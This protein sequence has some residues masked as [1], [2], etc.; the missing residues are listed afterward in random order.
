MRFAKIV[1]TLGPSSSDK[2]TI[3]KL[4]KAGMDVA[5][6]N[7]SHGTFESHAELIQLIRS[8]A[9]ESKH[10]ISI[11]QD[12]QGPKLRVGILP[13][14]GIQ[15]ESGQTLSLFFTGN[16]KEDFSGP[17]FS[18][19]LDVPN[20]D[21]SVKPGYRILLDDG[22]IELVVKKI[23]DQSVVTKVIIGGILTSHKG[24]N[25]PGAHL[26]IPSFTDKDRKDLEFGLRHGIDYVA[27]SFV[28]TAQDIVFVREV[29]KNISPDKYFTPIIA[30]LER[31]EAV[32]NLHE[33]IHVA[34]G[35]MVARGDLGV[36]TSPSMVPIMQKEIIQAA[37]RHAKIVITATQMLD[38]MIHNP[39][40]T[41]AEASDVANA[42]FD[43]TDAVMLSGETASGDYPIESV[44][45]MDSIVREAEKHSEEWGK[46]REFP[47]E[48]IQD[49]SLSICNAARELAHDRKVSNI[50]V[51]TQSGKTA[52]LMSKARPR[53]P[54]MAFTP[55]IKTLSLSNLYW[56][57]IPVLV[58]FSNSLEEMVHSVDH[59][60]KQSSS[61]KP[62]EQVVLISGFPV[63]AMRLPNLALLHT[64]GEEV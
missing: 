22:H 17:D 4:I 5:R 29:M 47:N 3:L 21:K 25:L 9:A 6:L 27:I 26:G 56:G 2:D 57:V 48:V 14:N 59:A 61:L 49:D 62:G 43:G 12:L 50:A 19:P 37:N 36:E 28:E 18:L 16:G 45:M 24:V 23:I 44:K 41:R 55:E 38:S 31:P 42:I 54:I 13:P 63:G 52:L 34:D 7:F 20:I 64:V 33:I 11:L 53:V 15:L 32:K 35:V 1:C 40:P 58:P 60:L 39:R 10:P 8:C 30:K 51:F 46:C